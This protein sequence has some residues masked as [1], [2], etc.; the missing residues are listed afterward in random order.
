MK[1]YP[2]ERET[3]F[4]Y[5]CTTWACR[6][7]NHWLNPLGNWL[8]PLPYPTKNVLASKLSILPSPLWWALRNPFTNLAHFWLGIVPRGPRYCWVRP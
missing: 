2:I 3:P 7:W 4:E 1:T 8:E 5:R 6:T